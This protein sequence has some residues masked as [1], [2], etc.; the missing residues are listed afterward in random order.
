VLKAVYVLFMKHNKK[1]FLF[2]LKTLC[3]HYLF[4]I[5]I[6]SK[7]K[8]KLYFSELIPIL[9]MLKFITIYQ[10]HLHSFVCLYFVLKSISQFFFII[11]SVLFFPFLW[12]TFWLQ[13][14]HLIH[15]MVIL[16]LYLSKLF[17]LTL[18]IS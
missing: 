12:L 17:L 14:V 18:F 3:F 4:I 16:L 1:T 9:K 2:H 6:S 7:L 8:V 5:M 10:H 15:A 11:L 13:E